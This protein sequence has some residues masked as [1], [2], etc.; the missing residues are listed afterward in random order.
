[1][2]EYMKFSLYEP[3]YEVDIF[4]L[5]P[6]TAESYRNLCH[7]FDKTY[8][9]EED[10]RDFPHARCF[11]VEGSQIIVIGLRSWDSKSP[12][13]AGALAHECL[14]AAQMILEARGIF[15]C[16][17]TS[18]VYAYL[19]DSLVRRATSVLSRKYSC[20]PR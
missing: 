8:D 17:E 9:D 16:D 3:C 18:E 11:E 10:G 14:H 13:W 1:M 6:A 4:F 7:T 5:C 20:K 15:L 12:V 19:L 2:D